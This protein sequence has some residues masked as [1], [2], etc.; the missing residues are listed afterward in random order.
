MHVRHRCV[1]IY[2]CVGVSRGGQKT[3]FREGEK[4]LDG[5][6]QGR[7]GGGRD[8]EPC[9]VY[10]C[11]TLHVTYMHVEHGGGWG[12]GE[13]EPYLYIYIYLPDA[14]AC[15][16]AGDGA[17]GKL[18]M[19]V[20]TGASQVGIYDSASPP[21]PFSPPRSRPSRISPP[22]R[23]LAV[24]RRGTRHHF[25]YIFCQMLMLVVSVVV[26]LAV[27]IAV[28]IGINNISPR[29]GYPAFW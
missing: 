14:D 24:A 2:V 28:G 11:S 5:R 21:P 16:V 27:H 29:R 26:G 22:T 8:D 17:G 20:C 23:T 1:D 6:E 4:I 18:Y 10:I 19:Y 12:G 15:R 9:K 25:I 3:I 13:A 7:E